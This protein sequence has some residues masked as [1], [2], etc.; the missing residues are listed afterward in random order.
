[1]VRFAQSTALDDMLLEG[2][3]WRLVLCKGKPFG[4]SHWH[5]DDR[6]ITDYPATSAPKDETDARVVRSPEGAKIT[7]VPGMPLGASEKSETALVASGVAWRFRACEPS[8]PQA[9]LRRPG[10]EPRLVLRR[11]SCYLPASAAGDLKQWPATGAGRVAQTGRTV[12]QRRTWA[13][14]KMG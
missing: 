13:G 9:L 7:A 10:F 4:C 6:Q 12:R 11:S 14:K 5:P 2:E 3:S 1:V 8:P